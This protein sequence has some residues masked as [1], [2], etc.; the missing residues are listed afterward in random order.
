[1][2]SIIASIVLALS[3]NVDNLAVGVAYGLKP[4]R[5]GLIPNS[6]IAIFSGVST[7]LA[8]HL[9]VWLDQF[10]SPGLAHSFASL[11]LILF[12]CWSVAAIMIQKFNSSTPLFDCNQP[13]NT[14]VNNLYSITGRNCCILP[15]LNIKGKQT[16]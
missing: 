15:L 8:M 16:I 3:T 12:G 14:L 13:T 7:F 10:F 4:N 2:V 9:G 11:I 6:I 5:I 1:M